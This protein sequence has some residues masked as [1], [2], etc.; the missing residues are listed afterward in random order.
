MKVRHN[1]VEQCFYVVCV[2]ISR[3]L[4]KD[5]TVLNVCNTTCTMF[6]SCWQ[7]K[8]FGLR[9]TWGGGKHADASILKILAIKSPSTLGCC[10]QVKVLWICYVNK[11]TQKTHTQREVYVKHWNINHIDW[12]SWNLLMEHQ[13]LPHAFVS[14]K[15]EALKGCQQEVQWCHSKLAMGYKQWQ[16]WKGARS[17]CS[18]LS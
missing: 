15:M 13:N 18:S 1:T 12:I 2:K 3:C 8:C 6:T 11:Y 7:M 17:A 16:H 10:W 5:L 9:E 4:R 14:N